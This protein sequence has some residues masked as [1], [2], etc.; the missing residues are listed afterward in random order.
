ML[1]LIWASNLLLF[2]S[3]CSVCMLW[4][5]CPYWMDAVTLN[6]LVQELLLSPDR[7]CKHKT[8]LA[9][10]LLARLSYGASAVH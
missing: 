1:Y 4:Q 10:I 3:R 8:K 9:Q 2:A 5:S 7:V 6:L